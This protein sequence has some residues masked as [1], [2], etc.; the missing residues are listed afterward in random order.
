MSTKIN[1]ISNE[2]I[3]AIAQTVAGI[4]LRTIGIDNRKIPKAQDNLAAN[5]KPRIA[6]NL[7]KERVDKIR[8]GVT[9][10]YKKYRPSDED[11]DL[12]IGK[13]IAEVACKEYG[14]PLKEYPGLLEEY[15]NLVFFYESLLAK[16]LE[17]ES[18]GN[19]LSG[20]FRR[21]KAKK[22]AKASA[23][24]SAKARHAEQESKTHPRDN[25]EEEDPFQFFEDD[26]NEIPD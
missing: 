19:L 13:A 5:I 14:L 8:I 25:R 1:K 17:P 26:T 12:S 18:V 15:K 24:S 16:C 23:E 2:A 10:G 22:K 9:T 20:R 4:I 6:R 21:T 3:V 7:K 11:E